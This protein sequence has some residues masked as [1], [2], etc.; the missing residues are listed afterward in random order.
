[1][2]AP[3]LL[4]AGRQ[5]FLLSCSYLAPSPYLLRAGQPYILPARRILSGVGQVLQIVGDQGAEL[6]DKPRIVKGFLLLCVKQCRTDG[7]HINNRL[8]GPR[9][10]LSNVIYSHALSLCDAYSFSSGG[11]RGGGGRGGAGRRGAT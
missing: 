2:P 9:Q 4:I 7:H 5:A 11:G 3:R 6:L 1:M 8:A 10:Y